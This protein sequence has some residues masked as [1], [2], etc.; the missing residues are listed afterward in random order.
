L[1]ER[2]WAPTWQ[3][4]TV[5]AEE[6]IWDVVA[7]VLAASAV[8]TI[9][10]YVVEAWGFPAAG[11]LR[12][13]IEVASQGANAYLA[14]LPLGVMALVYWFGRHSIGE[15]VLRRWAIWMVIVAT[16][17][18]MVEGLYSTWDVL[19]V[20]A[21]SA[22][23]VGGGSVWASQVTVVLNRAAAVALGVVVFLLAVRPQVLA[24]RPA[25]RPKRDHVP[26]RRKD[27]PD[28]WDDGT[29]SRPDL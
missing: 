7:V 16:V 24:S 10:A 6:R 4:V 25:S 8:V 9:V 22:S 13:R 19:T 2:V 27:W 12:G 29:T 5:D 1:G 26:L 17:A 28:P 15:S 23:P 11:G 14:L 21:G 18:I 3:R 20:P